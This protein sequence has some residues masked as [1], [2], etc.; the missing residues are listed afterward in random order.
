MKDV[1]P[2]PYYRVASLVNRLVLQENEE[3]L[4]TK[5]IYGVSYSA[6]FAKLN[7]NGFWEKTSGVYY[8][9]SILTIIDKEYSELFSEIWPMSGI[10]SDGFAM[11]Q[12]ISE[13]LI[14]GKGFLLWPTPRVSG[15]EGYKT[16][17]ERK[18][19]QVAMSYLEANV[20]YEELNLISEIQNST[21]YKQKGQLNPQWVEPLMGFPQGWTE[22]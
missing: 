18:G 22:V 21:N 9:L 10:V 20:E 19:H 1:V 11:E 14:N 8:Q 12:E 16:R 4:R 15:Q 5:D 17:A 6:S 3:E 2:L 7:Q 13:H